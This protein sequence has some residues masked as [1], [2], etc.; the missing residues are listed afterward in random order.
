MSVDVSV[1]P[2]KFKYGEMI[3]KFATAIREYKKPSMI[4]WATTQQLVMQ[5]ESF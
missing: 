4:Q 3:R 5:M 1:D 2:P